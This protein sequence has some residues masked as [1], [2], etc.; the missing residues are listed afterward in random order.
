[1]PDKRRIEGRYDDETLLDSMA[2]RKRYSPPGGPLKSTMWLTRR[3]PDPN[4]PR[5]IYIGLTPH[6]R[7]GELRRW[8][9]GLPTTPP[10]SQVTL[11]AVGTKVLKEARE[12]RKKAEAA[13]L[14]TPSR[15]PRSPKVAAE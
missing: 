8:E 5:A 9:D 2:V 13:L 3:R 10:P 12:R 4:F 15:K 14:A 11:G 6:F 7:L 1:M